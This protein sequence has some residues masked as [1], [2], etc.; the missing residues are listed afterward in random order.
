[1]IQDIEFIKQLNKSVEGN[2][3]ISTDDI[4][5]LIINPSSYGSYEIVDLKNIVLIK[6]L[7]ELQIHNMYL[8][9]ETLDMISKFE[10]LHTLRFYNCNIESL[11]FVQNLSINEL[12]LDKCTY[13]NI[14]YINNIKNLEILY[15]DNF[16]KI[17]LKDIPNNLKELSLYNST[18]INEKKLV[19]FNNL[20]ILRIEDSNIK[21]LNLC[22]YVQNLKYLIIDREQINK[23]E[24]T[25]KNMVKNNI[26]IVDSMNQSVVNYY[27]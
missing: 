24:K 13:D 22:L 9:N 4:L 15:L 3:I 6:N 19:T 26:N 18:V 1:M 12:V 14:T 5:T 16:D 23:N 7:N 11:K 10:K 27:G 25:I 17:D 20:E 8:N 21:D 2:S